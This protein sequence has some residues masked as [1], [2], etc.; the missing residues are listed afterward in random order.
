MNTVVNPMY[1]VEL[2][3]GICSLNPETDRLAMPAEM[4]INPKGKVVNYDIF[5]S[6]IHSILQHDTK[7][8]SKSNILFIQHRTL[9]C[10]NKQL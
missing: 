4:E 9:Q 2:S 8:P 7:K 1:P 5:E 3:N 10:R 6:V